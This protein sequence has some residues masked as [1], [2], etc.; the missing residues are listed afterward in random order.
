METN[1]DLLF[2]YHYRPLCLYALHYLQDLD[3]A[4]DI[5]QESFLRLIE[6]TRKGAEIENTKAYLY[7]ATRNR[8]IDYLR[9]AGNKCEDIKPHDIDGEISDEEAADR[10]LNEAELWTAIDALPARQREVLLMSKRDGMRYREIADELDISIKTVEH[11]ISR[12]LRTLR[13]KA[14]KF[15][16]LLSYLS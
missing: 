5:V 16:Y 4:E 12:A 7:S 2:R 1:T 3:A 9:N 10:S 6:R 13:G 8:C 15:I 11:L 14:G